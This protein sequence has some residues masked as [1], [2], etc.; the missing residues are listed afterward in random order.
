MRYYEIVCLFEGVSIRISEMELCVDL[1]RITPQD[2]IT[3]DEELRIAQKKGAYFYLSGGGT[4][5]FDNRYMPVVKRSAAAKINPGKY[6][7]FTGRAEGIEEWKNPVSVVRELFEEL[8]IYKDTKLLIPECTGFKQII[9][10]AYNGKEKSDNYLKLKYIP[11][12]NKQIKVQ[13]QGKES[14]TDGLVHIGEN[15]DINLL[16]VFSAEIAP[17]GLEMCDGETA[18][19]GGG[20][21]IFLLDITTCELKKMSGAERGEML[22]ICRKEQMTPHLSALVDTVKNFHKANT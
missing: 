22:G 1:D 6:S 5:I 13:Y 4:I 3:N 17:D 20:R 8:H 16:F 7:L 19:N 11:L 9:D 2:V 21:E 14:V 12:K 15:G 10:I 18:E